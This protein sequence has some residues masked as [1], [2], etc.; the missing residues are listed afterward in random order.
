MDNNFRR[1]SGHT[2]RLGKGSSEEERRPRDVPPRARLSSLSRD[3]GAAVGA[4]AE[5]PEAA[6]EGAAADHQCLDDQPRWPVL[7]PHGR[8]RPR[9]R[10][11]TL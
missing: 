11:L 6:A 8:R 3:R 5:L 9:L 2:T 7:V 4:E 10:D 1:W